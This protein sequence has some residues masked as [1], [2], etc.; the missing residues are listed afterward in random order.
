[1]LLQQSHPHPIRMHTHDIFDHTKSKRAFYTGP[2]TPQCRLLLAT[3]MEPVGSHCTQYQGNICQE[4]M[5]LLT[6]GWNGCARQDAYLPVFFGTHGGRGYR[7]QQSGRQCLERL[8]DRGLHSRTTH[9]GQQ[10]PCVCMN[11]T[12]QD[13]FPCLHQLPDSHS[14]PYGIEP[15]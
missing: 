2:Q 15:A 9:W 3:L 12:C 1:M 7:C 8:S 4:S 11:S 5:C 10:A 13:Y 14:G 6:C